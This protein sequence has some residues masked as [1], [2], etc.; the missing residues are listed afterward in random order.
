MIS[1]NK[2][3]CLQCRLYSYAK[4][5]LICVKEFLSLTTAHEAFHIPM[6]VEAFAEYNALQDM[7]NG[8][9]VHEGS[10]IWCYQFNKGNFQFIS[11]VVVF[12]GLK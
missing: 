12:N 9:S 1:G 11:L 10:D 6:S 4:D 2:I 5:K 7:L 8:A 3:C